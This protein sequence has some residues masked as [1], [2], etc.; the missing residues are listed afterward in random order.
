MKNFEDKIS[1]ELLSPAKDLNTG[2][3]AI[4]SGAD[5]VYIGGP[6]FSARSAAG[7]SWE[8]IRELCDFAHQFYAKVYVA[9]NTIFYDGEEDDV[10]KSL[11]QAYNA[12]ADAIIIQ[13]PGILEMKL[14]PIPVIASTQFHNY[15]PGHVKFLQDAGISRVILA[16]E[17]SL[18]QIKTIRKTAPDIELEAFVHGAL[19]VSFS[20]RCY[21]S[22]YLSSRSANRGRCMQVCRLPFDLTDGKGS[23]IIK[24]KY[25]LSPKDLNLSDELENMLEAGITSFKIEGRLKDGSYV[26]NVTAF[27]S[28]KFNSIISEN[29]GK[30]RRASSGS[31]KLS[32]KADLNKSFNRGFTKYFINGRK[33]SVIS[34][35]VQKSV[36]EFVG[37]VK[38]IGR[39]YFTLDALHDLKNGDGICW[40][41][42]E[43]KLEGININTVNGE[44]VFPNRKMPDSKG[45]KIFRNENPSFEK[46]VI[47]GADRRVGVSVEIGSSAEIFSVRA[48]DEDGNVAEFDFKHDGSVSQNPELTEKN[49]IKQFSKA[50]NTIFDVQNISQKSQ[51]MYFVPVSVLN[52]W[53]REIL[54]AL[55]KARIENYHRPEVIHDKKVPPYPQ[56]YIDRSYNVSNS[57]AE[58]FYRKAGAEKIEQANESSDRQSIRTLMTTRHCIKH[59]L[60]AC[61]KY[62][63]KEK[64]NEPLFLVLKGKNY[65]LDFDCLNCVMKV[66]APENEDL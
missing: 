25:L 21:F 32:Y 60:N 24:E 48:E 6:G 27:Y 46:A 43:G 58:Q 26:G 9:V 18:D 12:G 63:G 28:E 52:Q 1:I 40:I 66:M 57:L 13:D 39:D 22:H 10:Q 51:I 61:S 4:M 50:G 36:G 65:R 23:M 35:E 37:N 42:G 30:Y 59:H 62:G 45:I 20:G 56:K 5:A 8:D 14:P 16:R 29:G 49:F 33:E 54:D 44:Q 11:D 15:D 64:L 17:L 31:V 55:L 19:C 34:P 53:R 38:K 47:S 41:S 7:N 3:I 2:K